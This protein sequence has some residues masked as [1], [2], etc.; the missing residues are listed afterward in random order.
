MFLTLIIGF[1]LTGAY[2]WANDRVAD[3]HGDHYSV[4]F[5]VDISEAEDFDPDVHDIFITGSM[6]EWADPGSEPDYAMS[7]HEDDADIYTIT[8][9]VEAGVHEY[10]Y[11]LI[12]DEP[13]W[14][15]GE[16]AGDPNREVRVSGDMEVNDVWGDAPY[17]VTFNVDIAGAEGFDPDEHDIFIT[18][19]M[20]GWAE[21]GS[22]PNFVMEAHEDDA[23]VYTITL[24]LNSGE[25]EYKYF[26]IEDEPDWD[27]GEWAGDPNRMVTVTE[28]MVVEDT[29]GVEPGATN[30]EDLAQT[31]RGIELKQNYPNPFNPTTRIAYTLDQSSQVTLDVY[32]A[33][34]Q[35][36]AT[37]VNSEQQS[38]GQYEYNFNAADL[39]SGIYMYRLSAGEQVQTR[40]MTLIK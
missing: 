2:A 29:W 26:M 17:S 34:G 5:N 11:F 8:I 9:D 36:V 35:H 33:L 39:S 1:G 25:Y 16:W 14:D 24:L 13:D 30:A 22:D 18:G 6:A 31:P 3:E 38:A 10:K 12:E 7:A 40:V 4:T 27:A 32:N 28:D 15:A 20:A 19:S 21:P 37:L 23:D